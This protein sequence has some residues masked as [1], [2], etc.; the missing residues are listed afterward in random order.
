[1]KYSTTSTKHPALNNDLIGSNSGYEIPLHDE[2]DEHDSGNTIYISNSKRPIVYKPASS[3]RPIMDSSQLMDESI[4]LHNDKEKNSL[5]AAIT[6]QSQPQDDDI[7][8][9][10]SETSHEDNYSQEIPAQIPT[11]PYVSNEEILNS[12]NVNS[13]EVLNEISNENINKQGEDF[14][15]SDIS[16]PGF[17]AV[18]L[19]DNS[20]T[21]S[22]YNVPTQQSSTERFSTVL[23]NTVQ[24]F[25][26]TTAQHFVKVTYGKPGFRPKPKP[27]HP[28]NVNSNDDGLVLVQT[29][30]N[31]QKTENSN[32]T[33]KPNTATMSEND[34][35]SIE[36]I[37]LMLNDT[38]TG[39][40]YES[41]NYSATATPND[42]GETT[43][44]N[45]NANIYSTQM[46][47]SN[48]IDY[49]KYGPNSYFITTRVPATMP[50]LTTNSY[51]YSPQST[52]RLPAVHEPI[53]V[54]STIASNYGAVT[55]EFSSNSDTLSS[56]APF[57]YQTTG[58]QPNNVPHV[59]LTSSSF[60][61]QLPTKL[62][63]ASYVVGEQIVTKGPVLVHQTSTPKLPTVT[64]IVK[65]TKKPTIVLKNTKKPPST[66][67]V[68]GPTT[69]RPS[70]QNAAT[71]TVIVLGPTYNDYSSTTERFPA[72]H[73]VQ[74]KPIKQHI[75][76]APEPPTPTIHITPKP[77][78]NLVT[79]SS[80]TQKPHIINKYT[81]S[82]GIPQKQ[83]IGSYIYTPLGTYSPAYQSSTPAYISQFDYGPVA[84]YGTSSP[85]ILPST[86]KVPI[87]QNAI[88]RPSFYSTQRPPTSS[89]TL[90]SSPIYGNGIAT[91]QPYPGYFG[92]SIAYGPQSIE[93][94]TL[95]DELPTSHNDLNNFP[96]VR[97]P[98]LNI[99][100]A[101]YNNG[102]PI[103]DYDFSTPQFVEDEAL[104]DKM[105]LLVSKIVESLQD[106]FDDLADVVYE[107]NKTNAEKHPIT[108]TTT[109]Y[110][111]IR[112]S[113]VT[114]KPIVK[115]TTKKPLIRPAAAAADTLDSGSTNILKPS[116]T[117]TIKPNG[118][119]TTKRPTSVK[120]TTR[121][122]A[123]TLSQNNK[124]TTKKPVTTLSTKK[125][126]TKVLY[127][128]I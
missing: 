57:Q 68:T 114:K 66:S 70:M 35:E 13:Y 16:H 22:N 31:D 111:I 116:G 15:H 73:T 49:N 64:P 20:D 99:S 91:P 100:A 65:K 117:P 14:T 33:A 19:D 45:S 120:V 23:S 118:Q 25:E 94:S 46:T 40:Q 42:Y 1:M 18:I 125:P 27:T 93:Y 84:N 69:P 74:K 47:A 92:S 75:S 4:S 58:Y 95:K 113:N 60:R 3:I 124:K 109:K 56:L 108:T 88:Y 2:D 105:G 67:Y 48:G 32:E 29:L 122:P 71:P 123:S 86:Q 96:P 80:W 102:H 110:S 78:V 85:Y 62:P 43:S 98:N 79:S 112:P 5:N 6:T 119:Q 54:Q 81:G 12:T 17:D 127:E 83:P 41:S 26:T 38:N 34:I 101:T 76:L 90:F 39:P 126:L 36:S 55:P 82:T 8:L 21:N 24:P 107:T 72:E 59:L 128:R 104:K 52:Q 51:T 50:H 115:A 89:G 87:S 121:K 106:N 61:P 53:Y 30:S 77:T 44:Y 11:G 37:I 97:N 28:T 63:T 103:Q 7:Y 10:A 9:P